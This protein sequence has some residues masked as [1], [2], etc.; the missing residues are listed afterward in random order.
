MDEPVLGIDLGT[1]NSEAAFVDDSY[2]RI[3]GGDREGILPSC[4]GI[5]SDGELVVGPEARNQAAAWPERTVVSVK[6][7]MGSDKLCDLGGEAYSPSEIS[8]VILKELKRR[9]ENEIGSTINHAVITV[10]AYFTDAQRQ[11]TKE[12]GDIAG[13]NVVRIINEPTAAA[14]AYKETDEQGTKHILVYDLGGGTFDV[15]IVKI[16]EQVVEVLS[17]TGD[18][19]LGGDDFDERIVRFLTSHIRKEYKIDVSE[20]A[21]VAARLK[22]A[23]E[24]AK[25]E[26]S[27]EYYTRIEEPY[28]TED[29]HLTVELSRDDFEKMV[30]K[31]LEKTM[32]AVT[33][34]LNDAKLTSKDIDRILLVG[35]S[36]RIPVISTMLKEKLGIK[37][38][39][40]IDPDLCVAL[41][42]GIQAGREMGKEDSGVL[43][44]ITPYTF[45]TS[46][47]KDLGW[48]VI[49]DVFVPLIEKNTKLPASRTEP[50]RTMFDQQEQVQIDVFQ[51]EN[52]N[53]LDNILIGSYEFDLSQTAAGSI[54]TLKYDLDLN[55]ILKLEAVEKDTG[56]KLNAVIDN[57]FSETSESR[58]Q[59]SRKKMRALGGFGAASDLPEDTEAGDQNAS[60]ISGIPQEIADTIELAREKL[61]SAHQDDKDEII[62]LTEDIQTALQAGDFEK[63]EKL[64][65]ELED[66]LFYID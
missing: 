19:M 21:G 49:P 25:I 11:A 33:N 47:V 65:A 54:I 66:I 1:T 32:V 56:R 14:L 62:N 57:V 13:L 27:G 58:L 59:R 16:E 60:G 50:F 55:G 22:N 38:S 45:G 2:A 41:G 29:I 15:S 37:P 63:A 42:A 18:N 5:N 30:M 35:G 61:D 9:A 43:I 12:A 48:D 4:V 53:A 46:A 36:T 31:D 51:G 24:R 52:A 6:R 3:I 23:A 8:S 26:L 17:S 7:R 20:D 28:I 40:E 44:D 34:A 64:S 39:L 10:P